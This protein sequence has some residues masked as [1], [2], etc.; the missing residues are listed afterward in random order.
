MA[1]IR[2]VLREHL[3]EGFEEGMQYGMIGYCG[4][5][6]RALGGDRQAPRHGQE[7]RQVRRLED[8]PLDVVREAIARTSVDSFIALYERSRAG[9]A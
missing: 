1:T 3:P 5:L 8:V 4:P 6:P 9:R 2:S 7:L